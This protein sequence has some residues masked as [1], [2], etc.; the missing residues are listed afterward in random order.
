MF[1]LSVRSCLVTCCFIHNFQLSVSNFLQNV[2]AQLASDLS[3]RASAGG[4]G[5]GGGGEPGCPAGEG[6]G[7]GHTG[8]D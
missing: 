5:G 4:R 8:G 7:A 3:L 1:M 6:A 2:P